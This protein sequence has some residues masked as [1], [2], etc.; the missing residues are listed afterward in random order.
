VILD[1]HHLV[2][3]VAVL[4]VAVGGA[5]GYHLRA[6]DVTEAKAKIAAQET[7]IAASEKRIAEREEQF[8]DQL[9]QILSM[10]S[11]P[12]TTP[13]QIVERIPQYFPQLQP[14]L[15]QPVN[16]QTG[17]PDTTKPPELVFDMPQAKVLNDTLV[18]CKVC[19]V[20]RDKLK[21]DLADQKSVTAERTKEV[22]TWKTAA[23]GGSVWKRT[24]NVAKYLIIGGAIG[25]AVAK[26]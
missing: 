26:K 25:Y 3:Y 11:T 18:D 7:I 1:R 13:Q 9:A 6:L 5:Y 12:A 4:V 20:E 8:K 22:E 16:P 23:K 15:Q 21:L 19:S 10:K 2:L 17:K 24:W 14:T